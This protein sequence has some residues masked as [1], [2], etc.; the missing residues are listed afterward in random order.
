MTSS[1]AHLLRHNYPT[2]EV[3]I[4]PSMTSPEGEV[5]QILQGYIFRIFRD[6][7]LQF[8]C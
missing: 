1:L 6:Q 8:Y 3:I 2:Y 4:S 5:V 7:T